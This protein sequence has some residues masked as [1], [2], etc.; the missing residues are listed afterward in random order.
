MDVLS[1]F[2]GFLPVSTP[3]QKTVLAIKQIQERIDAGALSFSP[4]QR[5]MNGAI[6]R[7]TGRYAPPPVGPV[8][9]GTQTLMD[10]VTKCQPW[11]RI[12]RSRSMSPN[13]AKIIDVYF[14]I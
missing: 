8:K 10:W 4:F 3:I 7:D 1:P 12:G 13:S 5:D 2:Q 6:I 11:K 14:S 9:N